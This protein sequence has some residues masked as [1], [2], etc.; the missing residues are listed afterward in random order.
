[1]KD[2]MLRRLSTTYWR[3]KKTLICF[4][5]FLIGVNTIIFVERAFYY[6]ET[7]MLEHDYPNI[8]YVLSRATG[9]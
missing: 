4:L 3:E 5:L 7:K 1:M 8:F 2:Q 6:R 9:A